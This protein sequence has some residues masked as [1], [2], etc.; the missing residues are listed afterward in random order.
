MMKDNHVAG[1]GNAYYTLFRV[2]PGLR[3]MVETGPNLPPWQS[4]YLASVAHL[5][6]SSD[7]LY[8]DVLHLGGV[9]HLAVLTILNLYFFSFPCSAWEG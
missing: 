9:G 3:Q 7:D 1:E 2:R 8:L 6:N 5:I 4:S